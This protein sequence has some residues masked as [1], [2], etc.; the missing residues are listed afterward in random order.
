LILERNSRRRFHASP[1]LGKTDSR[2]D[3][4]FRSLLR[5]TSSDALSIGV[6]CAHTPAVA[7]GLR[8]V[9]AEWR[10]GSL[11]VALRNLDRL[12]RCAPDE[13]SVLAPIYGRLLFEAGEYDPALRVIWHDCECAPDDEGAAL[14]ILA[15]LRLHRHQEARHRLQKALGDFCVQPHGFLELAA[16]EVVRIPEIKSQGWIGRLPNLDWV[17]E[18]SAQATAAVLEIQGD[19]QAALSQ[20]PPGA[21]RRGQRAFHFKVRHGDTTQ[22]IEASVLGTG[23]LG[24]GNCIPKDF[25]L[26]GRAE[27]SGKAIK[28]WAR[29]GWLPS[30][31]VDL[32]LENASGERH[33]I[34]TGRRLDVGRRWPFKTAALPGGLG[35]GCIRISARLPDGRW[36]PLPDS[37]LLLEPAVRLPEVPLR[38]RKWPTRDTTGRRPATGSRAEVVDVII[39][40]YSGRSESMA[41]IGSVLA[42]V[43]KSARVIVVDDATEDAALASGL[44]ELAQSGLITLLRNPA[45]LGFA[46]SVNRALVLNPT[47]DVVLLN[48]DTQVFGDW[49]TQLRRAAYSASEVA[50]VTPLSNTGSIFSY[51]NPTGAP[52]ERRAAATLH[53]LAA[54]TQAG[55]SY[56]IPVGVGF[57]LYMRRECLNQVGALDAG[58]FAQGYGEESDFCLRARRQGWSHRLA[59]D[60]YVYHA[61]GVSFAGRRAALLERSRRLLNLRHPGYDSYIASFLDRN[62]LHRLRRAL[63][64]HRLA[65]HRG[66]FV[67]L[68]TLALPGGVERFVSDR[69][70]QLRSQGLSPLVLKPAA[71]GNPRRCELTTEALEVPSLQ[72]EIPAELPHFTKLLRGLALESI[73]IQH[74]LDLD[75]RLVEALC[76]LGVPYDVVIHDYAWICPRVTLIGQSGRYCGEPAI[77]VCKACIRRNGSQL[78]ESISISALRARSATWLAGARG[79]SAPSFDTAARMKRYFPDLHIAVRPHTTTIECMNLVRSP[80]SERPFR[81]ALI[82]AIG[83]HKGYQVLLDC[84]RDAQTRRLPIEFAI[85]GYTEKDAPLL[86]TGKVFVTGP[87]AE[88]ELSHLLLRE[89]PDLLW[90]PSVWPETWC[91]TL[92]HAL[93]SGLPVMAF[94]L[95]AIEERLRDVPHAVVLPLELDSKHIN[96]HLLQLASHW[97]DAPGA[98]APVFKHRQRTLGM[99]PTCLPVLRRPR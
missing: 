13:T 76:S 68:V 23:L 62:P 72:Y 21:A 22:P 43:G 29:V 84:A 41:C 2:R 67:L 1:W 75:R 52:I 47:H 69:R 39:P 36:Q 90:L 64:E 73:E 30:Q 60:V 89:R 79:V 82:G 99:K 85:I 50:T 10:A 56:E 6:R 61:G 8:L 3:D 34:S 66:R 32:R 15:L 28:G 40:V 24:S 44:D 78:H 94:R 14:V 7:R 98:A 38:L 81:V 35:R 9:A 97:K 16:S 51:P 55:A 58:V 74:F 26:D 42:T 59:A 45:N 18:L 20:L 65:E 93:S 31:R 96:D 49:L 80:S 87:Y 48:A 37:P 70:H 25:G 95:G 92:D 53:H 86:A 4:A 12:W 17:G 91:Y 77:P 63:D 27:V 83:H 5:R 54:S 11:S 88:V 46:A 71:P 33:V 57:C 19:G